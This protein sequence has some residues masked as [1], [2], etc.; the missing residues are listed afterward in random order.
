M[1]KTKEEIEPS[2][3]SQAQATP[4]ACKPTLVSVALKGKRVNRT[5]SSPYENDDFN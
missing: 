3:V 2:A 1:Q 4:E 5:N